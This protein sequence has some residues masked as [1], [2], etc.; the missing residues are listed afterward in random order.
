[1]TSLPHQRLNQEHVHERNSAGEKVK[2]RWSPSSQI[3]VDKPPSQ[4]PSRQGVSESPS[5]G[6]AKKNHHEDPGTSGN[7]RRISAVGRL[8]GSNSNNSGPLLKESQHK[9]SGTSGNFR[10][11]SALGELQQSTAMPS[12]SDFIGCTCRHCRI[13]KERMSKLTSAAGDS[14]RPPSSGN[15]PTIKTT[16]SMFL[17][18]HDLHTVASLS[19]LHEKDTRLVDRLKD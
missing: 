2:S 19:E 12:H 9:D 11:G 6:F 7:S 17:P 3:V 15:K 18:I 13:R 16:P 4:P 14:P 8:Q 1:M 10:R 5:S